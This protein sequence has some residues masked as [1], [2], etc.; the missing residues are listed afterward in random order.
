MHVA[1]N[2][3]GRVDLGELCTS[4]SISKFIDDGP[5]IATM[6][7]VKDIPDPPCSTSV[8]MAMNWAVSDVCHR[9][10]D[11]RPGRRGP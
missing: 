7:D 9:E 3:Y 6:A 4:Q 8:S 1:E 5:S 10:P 11:S 2:R